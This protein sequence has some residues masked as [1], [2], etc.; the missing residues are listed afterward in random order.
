M[1]LRHRDLQYRRR[2]FD[3]LTLSHKTQ[4]LW[5]QF[6][7]ILFGFHKMLEWNVNLEVPTDLDHLD[8]WID[9]TQHTISL[10]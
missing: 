3:W 4:N 5:F 9:G 2:G 10:L 1:G 6:G 8:G 7:S